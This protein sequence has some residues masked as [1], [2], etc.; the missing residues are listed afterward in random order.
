MLVNSFI[1]SNLSASTLQ[2]PVNIT[3]NKLYKKSGGKTQNF[4]EWHFPPWHFHASITSQKMIMKLFR[5]L[6]WTLLFV[7]LFSILINS[8]TILI[9]LKQSL[10]QK[11]LTAI[12]QNAVYLS[13][14]S[15]ELYY[16]V[17]ISMEEW[18]IISRNKWLFTFDN[19]CYEQ[20]DDRFLW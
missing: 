14:D 1:A 13:F 4:K 3:V 12:K 6:S 16:D 7:D 18:K 2:K 15:V 17:Y 20:H 10:I 19:G 8:W 5:R 11:N 9:L